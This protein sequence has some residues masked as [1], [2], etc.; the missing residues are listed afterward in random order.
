MA[1]YT[2]PRKKYEKRFGLIEGGE[3]MRKKSP[4]GLR[5]E[6]KQKVK[7]VYGV[8][9]RQLRRYAKEALRETN[10]P[11]SLLRKLE[12]RFD[13]VVFRLGFSLSRAHARQ[14]ISHGKFN[15]NGKKH[16]ISSHL[17]KEGDELMLQPQMMDNF[18]VQEALEKSKNLPLLSWLWK[19]NNKAKI[20]SLPSDDELPKEYKMDWVISFFV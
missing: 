18:Q 4:Y 5:L 6:E 19:E 14:L 17:L 3:K 16:N 8:L 13:N 20:L 2:G 7:F 10:P 12:T 9:D 11:I 1:R 15:L